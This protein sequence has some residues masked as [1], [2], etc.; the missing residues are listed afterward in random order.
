[1][2]PWASDTL[3]VGGDI[4]AKLVRLQAWVKTLLGEKE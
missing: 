1:V 4:R 2:L 3:S